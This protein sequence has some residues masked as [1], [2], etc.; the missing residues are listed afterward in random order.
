MASETQTL[1][2]SL[3]LQAA[4]A[5]ELLFVSSLGLARL[6]ACACFHAMSP[7]PHHRR[8]TQGFAGLIMLWT[9]SAVLA[10]AFQC[11]VSGPWVTN[12]TCLDEVSFY[13]S[14]HAHPLR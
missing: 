6:S 7:I 3:N 4:Y 9:L 10:A 1:T 11:G 13:E 8:A 12:A 14:D 2:N 5:G